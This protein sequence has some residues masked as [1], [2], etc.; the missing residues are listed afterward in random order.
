[1]VI[2]VLFMCTAACHF[3]FFFTPTFLCLGLL[4]R[5]VHG[6][7]SAGQDGGFT[8]LSQLVMLVMPHP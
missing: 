8:L 2:N 6:V 5:V 3:L 1:M 4:I 7:I